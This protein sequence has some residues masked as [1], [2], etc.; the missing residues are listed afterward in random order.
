MIHYHLLCSEEHDFEGWFRNSADYEAQ[1][2]A[3]HLACPVCGDTDIHRALMAPSIGAAGKDKGTPDT[4]DTPPQPVARPDP[5]AQKMA[6]MMR[7]VRDHVKANSDYVG[8]KFPEEARKIHY[9]ETEQRGI[10]GEATMEDAKE[11]HDEG[12]EFYP[13]PTL[14]EDRN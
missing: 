11:L 6:A 4:P 13:L 9:G 14:P 5:N 2:Q 10:H 8:D 7:A 12:I 3:G 1:V